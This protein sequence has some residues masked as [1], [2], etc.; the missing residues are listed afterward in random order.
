MYSKPPKTT[1][2]DSLPDIEV[3][4]STLNNGIKLHSISA[5]TQEVLRLSVAFEAG[6]YYQSQKLVATATLALLSEGTKNFTAA[7]IAEQ[8]DFLGSSYDYS[9]EKDLVVLT[10]YCLKKHLKKTLQTFS[11][12][13]LH[14]TFSEE[15]LN[16]YCVKREQ[17]LRIEQQRVAY[18][19]QREFAQAIY[20]NKSP[21]GAYADPEDFRQL[22]RDL[23]QEFYLQHYNST[24]CFAVLAGHIGVEE[25]SLVSDFL[26]KIPVGKSKNVEQTIPLDYTPKTKTTPIVD[27]VQS[28]IRVG[29]PTILQNHENYAGLHILSVA[30]GGYFGSRLMRNLREDKGYTYGIFAG[31][32]SYRYAAHLTIGAEVRKDS[33]LSALNEIK[34]EIQSLSDDCLSDE[35]FELVRNYLSGSLLR[36]LDGAWCLA[37]TVLQNLSL[38]LPYSYTHHLF[39]VVK[40]ITPK[41]LQELAKQYFQTDTM[42]TVIVG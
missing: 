17:Q 22:N 28:A 32:M 21:Y 39:D 14:P 40:N 30:L 20:G 4:I 7:Q 35:E 31:L 33:N 15:E 36:S 13:I 27:A 26:Q 41:R 9:P 19:A 37:D 6:T 5:G 10:I 34:L 3:Q 23:L 29:K 25:I 16:I 11:E 42:S 38:N 12:V 8:F 24:G 18:L 2:P 1:L